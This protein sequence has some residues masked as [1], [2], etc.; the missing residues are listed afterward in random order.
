MRKYEGYTQVFTMNGNV[1]VYMKEKL[2]SEIKDGQSVSK[3]SPWMLSHSKTE[4]IHISIRTYISCIQLDLNILP[5]PPPNPIQRY[6]HLAPWKSVDRFPYYKIFRLTATF[7]VPPSFMLYIVTN[8]CEQTVVLS[9]VWLYVRTYARTDTHTCTCV[10]TYFLYAWNLY[11][12]RTLLK[13]K[14]F[15][16]SLNT[17]EKFVSFEMFGIKAENCWS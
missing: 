9:G 7:H 5:P 17:L 13:G 8:C 2:R 14:S 4:Y 11:S 3:R 1:S 15:S 16:Q 12:C 10:I 6:C